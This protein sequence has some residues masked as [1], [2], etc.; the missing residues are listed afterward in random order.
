MLWVLACR[1]DAVRLDREGIYV[2]NWTRTLG[3]IIERVRSSIEGDPL[4]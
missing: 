4:S 3:M 2:K 1:P